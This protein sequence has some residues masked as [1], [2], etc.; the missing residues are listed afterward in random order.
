M[1]IPWIA[2]KDVYVAKTLHYLQPAIIT[3]QFTN[4]GQAV[5]EI[6]KQARILFKIDPSKEVIAVVNGTAALTVVGQALINYRNSELQFATQ[7]YTFP[8]SAQT[9]MANAHIVDIDEEGGPDL[10]L[11]PQDTDVLVIT[12]VLGNLCNL[13]K[14]INWATNTGVLLVFDNA[15]TPFSDYHGINSVNYGVASIVSLHH[16]KPI[17]FGEGGIIIIDQKYGA[18]VRRIINFGYDLITKSQIWSRTG[19]NYKMSEITAAFILQFWEQLPQIET[20]HKNLYKTFLTLLPLN[21]KLFPNFSDNIPFVSGF[22]ILFQ[23][24]VKIED[25]KNDN[26]VVRKY[27]KPLVLT[28]RGLDWWQRVMCFPCHT[29]LTYEDLVHIT[30]AI[31]RVASNQIHQ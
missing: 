6:E 12:N 1:E 7:S 5:L 4:G 30:T 27:Y 10:K 14:Y 16:T 26:M 13:D 23:H 24:P 31:R 19:G 15:A 21:V 17:G 22:L 18:E 8:A 2:H 11:V 29:K 25:F 3:N 20:I 9:S 28:G